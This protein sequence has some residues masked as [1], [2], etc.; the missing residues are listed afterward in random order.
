RGVDAADGLEQGGIDL[1]PRGRPTSRPLAVPAWGAAQ[2]AAQGDEM[3]VRLLALHEAVHGQRGRS[4]SRTRKAAAFARISRS[5]SSTF[6]RRRRASSSRCS[7]RARWA[8]GSAESLIAHD[9][10]ASWLSPRSLPT[11]R[12]VCPG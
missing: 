2:D 8:I 12:Y 10:T 11:D 5:S 9:R 4:V 6:T 7:S 3:M 1:A